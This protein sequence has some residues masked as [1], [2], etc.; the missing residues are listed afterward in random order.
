MQLRLVAVCTLLLVGAAAGAAVIGDEDDHAAIRQ[1]RAAEARPAG[2][3]AAALDRDRARAEA[4]RA[5][6]ARARAQALRARRAA[7][8]ARVPMIRLPAAATRAW[9]TV[10]TLAGRPAVW[11][12]QRGSATLL[13]FDQRHTELHLHAGS[14][15]P[16]VGGWRYGD[17]VAPSEVH[18]LIAGFNGG[19]KFNVPGNGFAEGGRTAVPLS[20][21]LG[22]I[23]TYADGGTDIGAWAAGVPAAGRAV[24]SVRQNLRLLV[25]HGVVASTAAGC[26]LTCWGSTLGGVVSPARSGLGVTAGSELVWA[27]GESLSPAALGR[28]L[29]DAS[30]VRAVELDINP[31]WVA[32][33]LYVHRPSGPVAVPVVPGQHGILGQ[34]RLPYFRD[35]FTVVSR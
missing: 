8:A 7:R 13:R 5:E 18:R 27:A 35:F 11:M 1:A 19:F 12:A 26:P 31:F 10:A 34:L 25:D 17:A 20:P 22:S 30:A 15:Y 4:A 6:A 21:G 24:V 23:V 2:A 28:A 29:V 9:Q 3:G 16:G 32:G 14:T 33:Y